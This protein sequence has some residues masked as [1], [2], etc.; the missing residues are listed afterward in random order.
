MDLASLFASLRTKLLG[1]LPNAALVRNPHTLDP[2]T[3]DMGA[4]NASFL[5]HAQGFPQRSR[6]LPDLTGNMRDSLT[7]VPGLGSSGIP[8]RIVDN[9][10]GGMFALSDRLF[11]SGTIVPPTPDTLPFPSLPSA[12][13]HGNAPMF[14]YQ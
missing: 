2:G 12:A 11:Q 3:S 10:D 13:T 7:S 4:T 9:G 6:L 1:L 14:D 8:G 5:G